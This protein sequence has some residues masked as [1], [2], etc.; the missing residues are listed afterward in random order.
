MPIWVVALPA[1][2]IG[3]HV[4]Q[5][6]IRLLAQQLPCQ[7]RGCVTLGHASCDALLFC[8]DLSAITRAIHFP[9][10]SVN[11]KMMDIRARKYMEEQISEFL[12]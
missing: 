11:L 5:R 9:D 4:C 1:P 8:T 10:K 12:R 7:C 2:Y 6:K 3:A